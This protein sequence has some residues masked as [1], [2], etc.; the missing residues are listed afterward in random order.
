M[1][2]TNYI[3]FLEKDFGK[4]VDERQKKKAEEEKP[5]ANETKE[6]IL[7]D[8]KKFDD[9]IKSTQIYKQWQ[10]TILKHFERAKNSA[11]DQG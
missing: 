11:I 1:F 4:E 3:K 9:G 6:K 5:K 8:Y 10:D 7:E 2:A